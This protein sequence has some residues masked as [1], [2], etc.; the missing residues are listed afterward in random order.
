MYIYYRIL[1]NNYIIKMPNFIQFYC[2]YIIILL[3][4]LSKG[5]ITSA[6]SALLIRRSDVNCFVRGR[7]KC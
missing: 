5:R 2:N 7:L 3:I 4:I 1:P 6:Y